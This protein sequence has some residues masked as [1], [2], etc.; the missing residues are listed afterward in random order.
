MY[1]SPMTQTT[2]RTTLLPLSSLPGVEERIARTAAAYERVAGRGGD[3]TAVRRNLLEAIELRAN[4]LRPFDA[5]A[6]VYARQ[7]AASLLHSHGP[8]AVVRQYGPRP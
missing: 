1:D 7:N 6:P 2:A 8:A 3:V 4:I 5:Y